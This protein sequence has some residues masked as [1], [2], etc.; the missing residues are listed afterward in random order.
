MAIRGAPAGVTMRERAAAARVIPEGDE[1]DDENCFFFAGQRPALDDWRCPTCGGLV[2]T[3]ECLL[4]LARA[5]R[6][7]PRRPWEPPWR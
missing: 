1:G 4:C 3:Q 5:E 6:A 2:Q 7:R